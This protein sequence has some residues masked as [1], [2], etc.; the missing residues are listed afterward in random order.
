ME[1]NV[2]LDEKEAK[3][4][5]AIS[6]F[7]FIVLY[8][9]LLFFA[10]F[11]LLPFYWMLATA[12][13]TSDELTLINDFVDYY[14][15]ATFFPVQPTFENF[16][17]VFNGKN[18]ILLRYI[19]NTL[20]VGV[21]TTLLSVIVTVFAAFAFS[22][23]SFRGRD[24]IFALLL[25][26]MMIPGEMMIITNFTTVSMWG[27]LDSYVGLIIPF[28][29]SV[30]YTFFLRQNFKQIPDELYYAAKVDGN[31]DF[32][33]LFKVMI[34]IAK[35]TIVTI[36]I[37]SLIGSWNAYIWPRTV[38]QKYDMKL[39]TD[40]LM[41]LFSSEIGANTDNQIMAAATV[42]TVPLLLAFVLFKKQIMRGVS[43]S[44]IKG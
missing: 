35:P 24:T 26:T 32:R 21:S 37:L 4:Y 5:K 2:Y 16:M 33:Y 44:G 7:K 40:G 9:I 20:I 18:S 22:R 10:I 11:T 38:S 29:A 17:N 3:K 1:N 39:V 43:R 12:L 14:P 23:L 8:L 30:F 31:S 15:R 6:V 41:S 27:W 34:P 28:T 42:V 19:G 36:T 13:K 25:S